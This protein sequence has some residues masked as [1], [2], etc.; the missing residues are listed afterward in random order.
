[1][2]KEIRE[3][4]WV[5]IIAFLMCFIIR[6][7]FFETRYH[8]VSLDEN[9]TAERAVI[10][11]I[12]PGQGGE[13]GQGGE[14]GRGG[15]IGQ[16]G[17][18]GK[19]GQNGESLLI[20]VL[21]GEYKGK[22]FSI[23]NSY[24]HSD[25]YVKPFHEK[26]KIIIKIDSSQNS[27]TPVISILDFAR[28]T[29]S[30]YLV[31]IFLFLL[32]LIGKKQGV[33]SALSL[34]ITIF[35]IIKAMI[36]LILRGYDPILASV[37]CCVVITILNLLI[38]TGVSTKS[39][40]TL[41]GTSFGVIAAGLLAYL[42]SIVSHFSGLSDED[43]LLLMLVNHDAPFDLTGI[44][45]AGI[46]IGTLGAVM[47][48]SMSIASSMNEIH[49]SNPAASRLDLVKSGMSIG[50]D[51]MGT[52]ADTL[53]LAYVGTAIPLIMFSMVKETPLLILLNSEM[54]SAEIL[55][56]LSGS[57]GI[58]LSI[59]ATSVCAA[60]LLKYSREKIGM[61]KTDVNFRSLPELSDDN[62]IG[63]LIP[64]EKLRI[65]SSS[66][67]WYEVLR[68]GEERG[69]VRKDGITLT[70]FHFRKS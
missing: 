13:I 37:G 8:S 54:I 38:I 30:F 33:K 42:V 60:L 39:L 58:I 9:Q 7:I 3:I 51:V 14:S 59:P 34:I 32:I 11:E 22:S 5:V 28:D 2:K 6:D 44:L 18:I 57:I 24:Y 43:S 53:I 26:N 64:N 47:D 49:V 55:R 27:E 19:S 35:I 12:V 36:P 20:K 56:A 17:E 31:I 46:I 25:Y 16:G 1:M 45:F 61:A 15:E 62:I 66:D 68:N 41:L 4:V 21:T 67:E 29:Y 70:R 10:L 50:K 65:V 52:M 48:V 23:N 40:S 69:W 63:R